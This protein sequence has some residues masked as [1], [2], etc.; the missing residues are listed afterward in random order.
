MAGTPC[1]QGSLEN[2]TL[3]LERF[4]HCVGL[5]ASAWLGL[6]FLL[7]LI[8]LRG[9][10]LI[11]I[12]GT[13]CG[14]AFGCMPGITDRI[15][16]RDMPALFF[17]SLFICF[18]IVGRINWFLLF[19]PL[20]VLF[21]ETACVL[22]LAY[23]FVN[24]PMRRRVLWFA[25]ALIL[26]G[27]TKV[28]ADLVTQSTGGFSLDPTVFWVNVRFILFGEFPHREWY[29][30]L[31][32]INHPIFINAGLLAAFWLHPFKCRHK[33]MLR[34]IVLIFAVMAMLWAIVCEYRIWFE[35]I[36]L[37]L[38]PLYCSRIPSAARGYSDHP[39]M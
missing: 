12:L 2:A 30:S 16:P 7:Y 32:R 4:S 33:S 13:F 20:A 28:V 24:E 37:C 22:V 38:F 29:T 6:V 3:H 21:K 5:Y 8:T 39:Q 17:Y 1:T 18:L 27:G 15:Y 34:M 35:L 19:L 9:E 31:A 36:P 11:P 14:V 25:V 10:S 23:L 26:G